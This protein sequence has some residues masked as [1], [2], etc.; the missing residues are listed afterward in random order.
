MWNKIKWFLLRP[1]SKAT[2]YWKESGTSMRVMYFY[3]NSVYVELTGRT[4][5]QIALIANPEYVAEIRKWINSL[6]DD[7]GSD[8]SSKKIVPLNR[9]LSLRKPPSGST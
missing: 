9:K 7:G 4:G 1:L 5:Y 2:I 8:G 3:D 6:Y